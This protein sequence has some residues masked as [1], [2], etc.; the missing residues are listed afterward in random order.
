MDT[1]TDDDAGTVDITL[2]VCTYNRSADLREMLDTVL[3]Q[4][5]GGRFTFEVLI[6][7]NNSTDDTRNLVER[8]IARGQGNVRYVFEGVQGKSHALN[9]GLQAAQVGRASC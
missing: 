4:V 1:M 6:V 9:R 7:D 3:A 2:L 5:T 8:Y